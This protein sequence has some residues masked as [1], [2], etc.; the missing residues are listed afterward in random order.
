MTFKEWYIKNFNKKRAV[1]IYFAHETGHLTKHWCLPYRD[2][3]VKLDGIEKAIV[4]SRETQLLSEGNVPT[5][6][7]HWSN[8]ETMN[9]DD[10]RKSYFDAD[11]MRLILD[12][13]EAHKV[14][15]ATRKSS[16]SNEGFFIL[17]ALAVGFVAMFYFFNAKFN[18]L[19]NKLADPAP[20]VEVVE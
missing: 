19:N 4:L 9:L 6:Y 13:D 7:V 11:E 14:F 18:D 8:C 17:I 10:I 12:N 15:S 2:N 3:T 5:F 1:I 16:I 20:I